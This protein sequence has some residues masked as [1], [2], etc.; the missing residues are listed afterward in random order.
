MNKRWETFLS[1]LPPWLSPWVRDF[2]DVGITVLITIIVLRI[3]FRADMIVPLVVVT[4]DS[5]V[6]EPGDNNWKTWMTS[7][8]IPEDMVM[9]FPLI[10]G[11]N[12][13]DM[14]LVRDPN[15]GLGDIIIYERDLDHLHFKSKDPIIHRVIG[16][17]YI[18]DYRVVG[19][20]GTL[21]CHNFEDLQTNIDFVLNCQK[22]AGYCPYSKYPNTD[23]FK[24]FI[25]KGDHNEGSDQC[26]KRLNISYPVTDAQV[27]GRALLRLPYIGWLKLILNF[28]LSIPILIFKVVTL[29]V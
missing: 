5:M 29:Q 23:S 28:I 11:F 1:G 7:R 19:S 27:T 22:N 17:A 14:I 12:M 4:S 13:G 3:I 6:H 9:S 21:D 15:A 2:V 16:V 10:S 26:S 20:E 8:S 18:E 24:F 25:T